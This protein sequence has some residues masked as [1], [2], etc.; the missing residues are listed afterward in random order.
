L[1]LDSS[2]S[3]SSGVNF[4]TTHANVHQQRHLRGLL[5]RHWLTNQQLGS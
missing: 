5:R 1:L 2:T 3:S 4:W